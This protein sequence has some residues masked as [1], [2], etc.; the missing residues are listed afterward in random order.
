MYIKD[1]IEKL[2]DNIRGVCLETGIDPNDIKLVAVTKNVNIDNIK[3]AVSCG[4]V[5]LGENR[6]QEFLT[7]FSTIKDVNWHIIGHLQRNKVKY[8]VGNVNL[9]QSVDSVKLAQE[10]DKRAGL[11]N[12]VQNVLIEVKTSY[13]ETKFGI[14]I[15]GFED[16]LED[17]SILSN[18][19]VKG[20]M[21][22]APK[23]ENEDLAR[24]YFKAA[25]DLFVKYKNINQSNI[26]FEYLSMGMSKDYKAAI[27]EGSNMVRIGTAIFGKRN[28]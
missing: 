13:E 14:T 15:D 19:T 25:Y 12:I 1:N 16:V 27:K 17:I 22:I 23:V 6:V 11:L 24:P 9:I 8:V 28:K 5:D 4:I 7:K 3:E 2:K 18:L 10:I 26:K 21:T 20:I